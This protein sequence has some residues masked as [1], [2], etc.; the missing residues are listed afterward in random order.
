[1]GQDKK[2][3]LVICWK[4]AR[5]AGCQCNGGITVRKEKCDFCNNITNVSPVTDYV[6][7]NGEFPYVWD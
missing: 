6:W 1:M 5:D 7:P 2:E 4:C 3:I